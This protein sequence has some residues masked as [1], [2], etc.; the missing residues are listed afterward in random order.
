M[1]RHVQTLD[2]MVTTKNKADDKAKAKTIPRSHFGSEGGSRKG[3]PEDSHLVSF[4]DRF[5]F[6]FAYGHEVGSIHFDRARGEIFYKGHNIRNME[7][8]D[9]QMKIFENLRKNLS[10]DEQGRRFA[11]DYGRVLDKVILEKEKKRKD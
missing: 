5:T 11:E 4:G 3:L 7:L 2:F 8:E 10:A 1:A 6:T 9:W